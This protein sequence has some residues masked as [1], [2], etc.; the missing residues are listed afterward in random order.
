MSECG[1]GY[2]LLRLVAILIIPILVC[3]A[4]EAS[5]QV[6][7]ISIT[8]A[9]VT[10]GDTARITIESRDE[11]PLTAQILVPDK[12]I[13]PLELTK[14]NPS[15]YA[16]QF[17][18]SNKD[19]QGLYAIQAWVGG[20]AHPEAIG[21]AT[22]LFRKIIGDFCMIGVFDTSDTKAD[23]EKYIEE[24]KGFGANFLIAHTI[25]TSHR[26]YYRSKICDMDSSSAIDQSYLGTLL[27]CADENGI[28]VMLSTSWD[29]TR[30]IPSTDRMKSTHE[31]MKELYDLYGRH[32]SLVGF[33]MYQEGSGIYYAPY[34]RKFCGYAKRIDPG[35]LT[36]CAPYM[37][38]PLLAGY[39]SAIRNLDIIIY[40]GMV[41]ASYRPDNRI[42]FPFRRVKDFGSLASGA[43]E[44][45]NKIV[46]THIE[47]F[48]YLE[49]A[50]KNLYITGYNN[51]YQQILSAATVPDNDGIVMFNYSGVIYNT[52]RKY[53]QF[54]SEFVRSRDAVYEGMKA[55]ELMGRASRERN[56]LAVYLPWTDFQEYTWAR[57]YY[58][59]FDAFRI[60]GI[61][62]DI[63]PYAP[64]HEESYPPYYPD[65]ENRHALHRLLKEKEV[66]VLPSISGL[67][68]PDSEL[69]KHFVEDGG[70]V[71]AFGPRIPMGTTYDRSLIFG[72]EK[73]GGRAV[74]KEIISKDALGRDSNNDRRWSLGKVAIPVWKDHGARVIAEFD[75]GSPA[76][77]VNSYGRG[78]TVSILTDAKTA[79]E[80]F[81]NLVRE[82]FDYVRVRRY[83]DI[84][85]TNRDCDVA[86]SKTEKGFTA[87]IVNHGNTKLDITL[88]PL[89]NLSPAKWENWV[90]LVK[91][92][93][94]RRS[95]GNNPVKITVMPRSFRLIQ[96]SEGT[97]D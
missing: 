59:A 89:E 87:A 48:G 43:K 83:V 15:V 90:D 3:A 52:V 13:S 8:P 85:G 10:V 37:D 62:V 40:Q 53:P 82:V 29:M 22:F 4:A 54:K 16:S 78:K 69:M 28:S 95:V 70:T 50:L 45:Q 67:N 36:A 66:L 11:R 49:N 73:P 80:R 63:L 74:H 7:T 77:V 39:L 84:I 76:I 86:V 26:V 14:V 23:M 5:G 81:P 38:N 56:E 55:F 44:L 92:E 18:V 94:I 64:S 6:I 42:K 51:I 72:I 47:T 60:L 27:K 96:M 21:K 61:P 30:K 35:L 24:M 25:I 34:V 71:I 20:E 65:R 46:L 9:R 41:M 68:R 91:G 93:K 12:G 32:P 31:I 58:D 75:D 2:I 1:R 19:P 79:A 57:Y 97:K 88:K 33:Y 17:I